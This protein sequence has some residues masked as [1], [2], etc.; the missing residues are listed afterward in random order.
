MCGALGTVFLITVYMLG[1]SLTS[2]FLLFLW[3]ILNY[4]NFALVIPQDFSHAGGSEQALVCMRSSVGPGDIV[5]FPLT[6]GLRGS[7]SG[8]SF[9]GL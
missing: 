9:R 5:V 6:L 8:V 2:C 1:H 4:L 3:G 7:Y